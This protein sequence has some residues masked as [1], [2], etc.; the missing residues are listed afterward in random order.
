V[1]QVAGAADVVDG[2]TKEAAIGTTAGISRKGEFT[3]V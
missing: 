3:E 1:G 2:G